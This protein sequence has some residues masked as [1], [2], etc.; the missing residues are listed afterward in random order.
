MHFTFGKDI[1]TLD[2]EILLHLYPRSFP[3]KETVD[4]IAFREMIIPTGDD[5]RHPV[6][7]LKLAV[8]IYQADTTKEPTLTMKFGNFAGI[9]D[10]QFVISEQKNSKFTPYL[11]GSVTKF[12]PL[13]VKFQFKTVLLSLRTLQA[14]KVNMVFRPMFKIGSLLQANLGGYT[15]KKVNEEFKIS[16]NA[17]LDEAKDKAIDQLTA[18]AKKD[19]GAI[20]A[21]TAKNKEVSELLKE[22]IMFGLEKILARAEGRLT[23]NL[24]DDSINTSAN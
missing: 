22:G 14:E 9:K 24:I 7:L 5:F 1:A 11:L 15:V 16:I 17:S 18:E 6:A 20:V 12:K 19:V 21:E 2:C 8:P 10:H 13:D 3:Y 23:S 4:N